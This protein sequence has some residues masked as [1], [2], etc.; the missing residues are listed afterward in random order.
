MESGKTAVLNED[1]N[2]SYEFA[3]LLKIKNRKEVVYTVEE[4]DVPEG[5]TVSVS[6]DASSGF[7]VTNTHKTETTE[8]NGSK[9]WVDDDDRDAIRPESITVNLLADGEV[10]DTK[11]VT[12]A[13][14]WKYSFTDLPKYKDGKEIEYTVSE[15]AV[16]GYETTVDGYDITNTHEVEVTEISV[17]KIWNDMGDAGNKRPKTITVN[18]LADG[19][20]VTSKEISEADGWKYTFTDLPKYKDGKEIEYTI[21]ED[22]VP[23]YSTVI[24]GTTIT[25]SSRPW[26]PRTPDESV[27]LEIKK[28]VSGEAKADKTYKFKVTIVAPDNTTYTEEVSLKGNESKEYDMV[29][30]G[31]KVTVLEQDAAEYIVTVEADGKKYKNGDTIELTKD[32]TVTVNN[33]KKPRVPDTSDNSRTDFW[34]IMTI[35]SALVAVITLG[36][37][38]QYS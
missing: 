32:T 35:L 7:T 2:W 15:E 20:V 6:G 1:N 17:N 24:E 26:T 36:K 19:E 31:S 8:V 12:E 29:E 14:G 37:K 9:T 16:E 3:T 28:T 38:K 27:K 11:T 22:A 34:M 33:N 4:V 18:V 23:H 13:D 21:S 30:L 5:Y 10:V 25:N